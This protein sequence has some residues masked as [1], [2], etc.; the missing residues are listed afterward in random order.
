MTI[1]ITTYTEDEFRDYV[2]QQDDDYQSRRLKGAN[3]PVSTLLDYMDDVAA[4]VHVHVRGDEQRGGK[5]LGF[6]TIVT[7]ASDV[8][9]IINTFGTHVIAGMHEDEV[10]DPDAA[11]IEIH[12]D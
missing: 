8:A 12:F 6:T 3:E 2:T 7:T 1:D 10:D 5:V 9:T 11:K 4:D